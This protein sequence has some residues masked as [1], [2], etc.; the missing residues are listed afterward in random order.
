M[1]RRIE[2]GPPRPLP[3]LEQAVSRQLVVLINQDQPPS[4]EA[5]LAGQYGLDQLGT[6]AI[7]LLGARVALYRIRD[8]RPE[9]QVIAGDGGRRSGAAGATQPSL[10]PRGR[11]CRGR[12]PPSAVR[13][14]EGGIARRT[15]SWRKA[16]MWWWPSSIRPWTSV[17]PTSKERWRA[18]SM[19]PVD[20]IRRPISMAPRSPASSARAACWRALLRIGA[21]RNPRV[22]GHSAWRDARD[23]LMGAVESHRLGRCQQG[24]GSEPELHRPTRSGRAPNSSSGDATS[25]RCGGGGRQWW[26]KGRA[27]L[28]RGLPRGDCRDGAR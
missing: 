9:Q 12:R 3:P 28:S 24:Q 1:P 13:P 6:E 27:G 14:S 18:R 11:S 4:V 19:P 2:R 8:R 22:P 10:P 16:A 21:A 25:C 15:S 17:I 23:Q 20:R 7:P 5:D 26:T